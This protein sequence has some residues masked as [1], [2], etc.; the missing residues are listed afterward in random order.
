MCDVRPRILCEVSE[1]NREA[2]TAM[3]FEAKY[4]LFDAEKPLRGA[5]P[6]SRCSWNTIAL[7]VGD[8]LGARGFW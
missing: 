2:A 1:E 3:F 8:D 5:A 7:P 4:N 6:L